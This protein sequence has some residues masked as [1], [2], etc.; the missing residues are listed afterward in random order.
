MFFPSFGLSSGAYSKRVNYKEEVLEMAKPRRKTGSPTANRSRKQG[1]SWQMEHIVEVLNRVAQG[2]LTE[3]AE[4]RGGDQLYPAAVAINKVRE[5]LIVL[6]SEAQRLEK[7]AMEGE[8]EERG[9]FS[10]L[11][12]AYAHVLQGMN[13]AL[14]AV[15]GPFRITAK[16]IGRISR[17]DIPEKITDGYRGDFNMLKDSLNQTIDAIK[18]LVAETERLVGETVRGN[19]KAR[20]DVGQFDGD[21]G[22]IIQGINDTLDAILEPISEASGVLEKMA[23]GD[24]TVRVAGDYRGEHRKLQEDINA[25]IQGVA[26]VIWNIREG[27]ESVASATTEIASASEQMASGAQEQTSQANEVAS[28]VEEM[29]Q[30]IVEVSKSAGEAAVASKSAGE[31][32]KRGGEAVQNTVKSID[33]IARAAQETA[34]K[35]D[36][37][38]RSSE[39]IG[40]I[41]EVIDD[42]AAQT[43]LLALNAAI[44]AARAG[45]HGRGFAVVADEVRKLAE[46]TTKATGEIAGMIKEMQHGTAEAVEGMKRATEEVEEGRRMAAG[47][48]KALEEIVTATERVLEMIQQVATASE[49]QSAASEQI[50]SNV[51]AISSVTKE[52]ATGAQQM[53]QAAEQLSQQTENLR[54]LV[55]RFKLAEGGNSLAVAAQ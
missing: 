51:Q 3:R 33:S 39:K 14:D 30:T 37:L 55:A 54:Q 4:L 49:E 11:N 44:E 17:G 53:A 42:I 40:G 21:Y 18:G 2:D 12:G 38:H 8:L 10:Q 9:D 13:S 31:V 20:G 52:T 5:S 48:G 34:A 29:T 25:A 35:V 41:I 27:A 45:E 16:Y 7:G 46:R 15:V 19:L 6:V 1:L 28:A 36:G 26:E 43:N 32:G 23:Q 24:L 22:R 50:S 47:A